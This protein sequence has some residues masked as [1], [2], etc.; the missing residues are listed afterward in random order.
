MA[1]AIRQQTECMPRI[2]SIGSAGSNGPIQSF[3]SRILAAR[4]EL[5]GLAHRRADF[6]SLHYRNTLAALSKIF[7]IIS[8]DPDLF[9]EQHIFY[10]DAYSVTVYKAIRLTSTTIRK[11]TLFMDK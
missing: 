9:L 11:L 4:F 10:E 2:M 7:C 8:A 3:G 6:R 5:R 1:G